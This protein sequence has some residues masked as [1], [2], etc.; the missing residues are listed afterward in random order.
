MTTLSPLEALADELGAF[1]ARIEREVRLSVATA[2]AELRAAAAETELRIDRALA[3]AR[4]MDG[5][6]GPPGERG[7]PGPPG[8]AIQ[9]PPGEPG[10]VGPPGA[11][12]VG[13][14]GERGEVGPAGRAGER[15]EPGPAGTFAPPKPWA[16]GISYQ[17]AL[18]VHRGSTYCAARDTAEEPPHEDWACVAAA[19]AAG[20]SF[21]VRGTWSAA[22]DYRAFDVVAVGGS[23]FVARADD[24]GTCPGDGWQLI[25]AAGNRGKPGE[26]GPRGERGPPGRGVKAAAIDDQG[27]LTLTH[28][29]G[30][31]V[32]CDFYPLLARIAR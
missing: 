19:G 14:A 6:A 23:S 27:L 13:P 3:I 15:G 8:E 24:P 32:V 4:A 10:P 2:L 20:R 28:D 1:A 18:V 5:P 12:V 31:T 21:T 11:A 22:A 7:E 26:Q 25:A 9:G 30:S 16:K 29:D 17:S